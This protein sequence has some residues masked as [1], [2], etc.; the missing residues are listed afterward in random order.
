[1]QNNIYICTFMYLSRQQT[2]ACSI[3]TAL[4]S[5]FSSSN[6]TSNIG[7]S[8]EFHGSC[9]RFFQVCPLILVF[10]TCP[11]S[12]FGWE[13][14]DVRVCCRRRI[15]D[16]SSCSPWRSCRSSVEGKT[17]TLRCPRCSS[18]TL[19]WPIK[20]S[21]GTSSRP[22]IS[23]H[24]EMCFILMLRCLHPQFIYF[25]LKNMHIIICDDAVCATV[26]FI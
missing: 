7:L 14:F 9:K 22:I 17:S 2:L 3:L 20:Y 23:F 4:L 15:S 24:E 19:H 6:K 12:A 18:V 13:G 16:R 26:S 11:L 21:A 1:M 5:E 10:L 25:N 8:M